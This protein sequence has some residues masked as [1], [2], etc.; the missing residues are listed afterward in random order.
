M[1]SSFPLRT[2]SYIYQ[3]F[4]H[5]L[6]SSSSHVIN[7][8]LVSSSNFCPETT[9]IILKG[10][11]SLSS[12]HF[13]QNESGTKHTG[14]FTP[15]IIPYLHLNNFN[16]FI[17]KFFFLLYFQIETTSEQEFLP[18]SRSLFVSIFYFWSYPKLPL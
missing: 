14:N 4:Q 12:P 16:S 11:T 17:F 8:Y 6:R 9:P 15:N 5:N 2:S 18:I 7:K 13:S 1:R 10:Q 3:I